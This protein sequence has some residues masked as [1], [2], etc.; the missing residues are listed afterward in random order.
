MGLHCKIL[1]YILLISIS[2]ILSFIIQFEG[3]LRSI[4]KSIPWITTKLHTN[5]KWLN[6][7]RYTKILGFNLRG[8]TGGWVTDRFSKIQSG[9]LIKIPKNG[10]FGIFWV[11]WQKILRINVQNGANFCPKVDHFSNLSAPSPPKMAH[12]SIVVTHPFR[13][14][15]PPPPQIDPWKIYIDAN[16]F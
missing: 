14:G 11:F 7:Y 3:R 6:S 4:R 12:L 10:I 2:W 8:V 16:I 9:S 1:L 13:S 15:N 5:Q